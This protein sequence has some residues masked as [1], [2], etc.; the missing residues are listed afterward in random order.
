MPI[1]H[2]PS[3]E[4]LLPHHQSL[5]ISATF[6]AELVE[7]ALNF[8]MNEL[9]L[10]FSIEF[11]PYNQVFQQLLD[12]TSLFNQNQNGI[13]VLLFRFEDWW[14]DQG[15]ELTAELL[16]S[17]QQTFQDLIG[18][19]TE[20]VS[21]SS[22]PFIVCLCPD[23][24]TALSDPDWL[25]MR[26]NLTNQL[27]SELGT[28][29]G[30]YLITEAEL[31]VYATA[32][33]YDA[34]RDRLGHIPFTPL[35]F[36]AL[37]SAIARKT[38]AIKSAPHKVIVLDCDNTIWKGI[39][40]EDGVT[41][42]EIPPAWKM[43]QE[44]MVAQ[45]QAGMLICLCSK[46]NEA[47]ALEV[48]DHRQDMVLQRE[49]L[50]SWR[51]NWLPK[52]ENIKSLAEELNLGLD[53]FIFIDDNPLECA[54][55][56]ANCPDVLT[57]QLPIQG[58]IPTFLRH[59]WAFDRLQVTAEDK[60]RTALYKQNLER[61]RFQR[62]ALTIDN[63]LAGLELKI[64]ISEPT[65]GQLPRVAQLTQRTN[66]FNF[67]TIRRSDSD[68]QQLSQSGLQCRVV[69]V[70]DRFGDYGL[71]GVMIFGTD[72]T[73]VN[74]DNFLLSCRVLGRGVEHRMLNYLGKIAEEHRLS[75]VKASYIPTKKN[76]PAL[77]FLQSI[78][79]EFKQPSE[80]GFCFSIPTEL[81]ATLSYK[82]GQTQANLTSGT[83]AKASSVAQPQATAV[84]KSDKLGRIANELYS[85]LYILEQIQTRQ[86]TASRQVNHPFVEPKTAVERLLAS[87]WAE[88]LHV[89]AVGIKDNY[90]DLGG[91]SLLSVELFAR[92]ETEFGRKLPLTA[93]I[94]APTVEQLAQLI[95]Q[96]SN[97][98]S[99]VL[100]REGGSKPPL[101]FVHDGDGETL[102]YRN[103]A[104][105]LHSDHPVYGLQPLAGEAGPILHTRIADMATYYIQKM[106]TVQSE[107]PY[108]V[109]GM[110]AGGVL[111]FEIAQQLQAQ[112]QKVAL[113]ALIDAAD[114]EAPK[115]FG[116]VSSSRLKSFSS[117]LNQDERSNPIKQAFT[118]LSKASRKI[119]NVVSYELQARIKRTWDVLRL[120][121]FRYYL[122]HSLKLP[123]F[124]HNL[125]VRTVYVFAEQDYTPSQVFQGEV[126]LFR[127]TEGNGND[128]PWIQVYSDPLF[129]WEKRVSD[130]VK[131]YDIPG[132]HS[133]MLQEPN[134]KV[135]A[136]KMQ[137]Y[138]DVSLAEQ[139][140]RERVLTTVGD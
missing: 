102:L 62:E 24:P 30:L 25:T 12:P 20:A 40:G 99:L 49:H 103:L 123:Q 83:T 119:T 75:S 131:V 15:S 109:G 21:R 13:N 60:Q 31:E 82:P 32:D 36:T 65:V 104:N 44:F 27:A 79:E 96:S 139:S 135:M 3:A 120:N 61:D 113:V 106:R 92:I 117:V 52:S 100:L 115:R 39:V 91:T 2:E 56:R 46:N 77:N 22:T 97:L 134:V 69:E 90:F 76:L 138:I 137:A 93:L 80:N 5:V 43:L 19:L 111:A 116:R 14:R 51:I 127:A 41:G 1:A 98:D 87:L 33:Y 50:V 125:S 95:S 59:V 64:E 58:D 57:L 28:L 42:I 105:H 10:P 122:D 74:I 29:S 9:D 4:F 23:S 112:G 53:S 7:P 129:G 94:E 55:V 118:I 26:H 37:G 84:A 72:Q 110:C 63:Y 17:I 67:T 89:E 70:S 73:A 8:W 34:Q 121:L 132:G 71:V 140:A 114:V 81:A 38:Y 16:N 54:E 128:E 88:L 126:V 11:A 136:E 35:F 133:S 6:T 45:Q 107:G 130:G 48:F 68:I 86:Q 78:A 85:P 124:L 47:D 66:Q 101:F 108:L 18:A